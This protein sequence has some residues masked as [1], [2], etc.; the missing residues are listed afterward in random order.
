MEPKT[1]TFFDLVRDQIPEVEARMRS[2]PGGHHPSLE[3]A[4]DHLLSSG[5]KRIRP[6][7]VLLAGGMLSADLSNS[8]T[9][10]AA[11]EM[12]HTATLVHDDL[13]DQ[14]AMRRGIPTIN[15]RLTPGATVLT[16]DYIF[17]LAANLAARTGSLP[18]ME[19]FADTLMTIVNGEITQLFG[20]NMSYS[21][22][23]YYERIYAKT[24]S[25]FELATRGAGLLADADDGV[26]ADLERF[27]YCIGVAFQI[28][29][30]VL[31]F[32]GKQDQVGKPVANDLR[33]GIITLPTLLYMED[34]GAGERVRELLHHGDMQDGA[35]ADLVSA[36]RA[37]GAI[38]ASMEQARRFVE[39][40][41]G[42]LEGMPESAERTALRD[43]AAYVVQ[44]RI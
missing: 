3:A 23:D 43:L 27:G 44:R 38:E 28:V 19:S 40:G 17:A 2:G 26:L 12:L 10:A 21:P 41:I 6:T 24:A 32:V 14:S 4:I 42:L 7:L 39:D 25:L 30:D 31:D 36:I 11:I 37:S 5:G 29:D 8:T 20:G 35:F 13:I 33:Q 15:A 18:V 16:G 34:D 9:L 22:D 1:A